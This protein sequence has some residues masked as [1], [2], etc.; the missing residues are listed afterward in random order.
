MG[1]L[2]E[3]GG[4]GL[5]EA[6]QSPETKVC[7]PPLVQE[8]DPSATLAALR[9]LKG[10]PIG[11]APRVEVLNLWV[12][13]PTQRLPKTTRKHR[14]LHYNYSFRKQQNHGSEV[15]TK[16]SLPWGATAWGTVNGA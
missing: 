15:A 11:C 1:K 8:L 3:G 6:G 7:L 4:N 14:Y 5:A 9:R 12:A 2:W 10:T 16:M 13:T